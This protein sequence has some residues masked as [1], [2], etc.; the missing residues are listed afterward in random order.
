PN[1]EPERLL[2]DNLPDELYRLHFLVD[3]GSDTIRREEEISKKAGDVVGLI[4]DALL[5]QYKDPSNPESLKSLNELCV[6]IVFLLYAEDADVFTHLQFHDYLARHETRDARRALI[7][8]FRVLDTPPDKRDPYLEAD[9]A[10]FP[11]VNGGLFANENIEIP[12]FTDEILDL[13]LRKGSEDFNWKDISPTIFGAVFESTLNPETRRSGGMHYTSVANIHK[14]ID[15][16]FLDALTRRVDE[17]LSGTS[18]TSATGSG[19][20]QLSQRSQMS[21]SS[22]A[23]LLTLQAE[24]ASLTFLD[25]ACG[26]GNFLTETYIGL[27]RLENRILAALLGGQTMLDLTG[28]MVKVSL[29]QFHGLEINDFAVKVAKTA[30]WIAENQMLRETE[31]IAHR[32]LDFLPLKNYDGIVEGNALRLDWPRAD[33]IIGNPP[34]VG[35]KMM[36][37]EQKED[38]L[39]IFGRKWKNLGNMD[40]VCCWHKKAF[41]LMAANQA[42]RAALVSTNSITQGQA[43]ASLL[44]PLMARGLVIDFAHRTFRWDSESNSKAH[45]HCVIIGFHS[46]G[47]GGPPANGTTRFQR[48]MDAQDAHPTN[49]GEP[50]ATRQLFDG[51]RVSFVP[52]INGYL[53]PAPDVVIDN[54]TRPLC[55]VPAMDF[56]NMPNDGGNLLLTPEEREAVLREEPALSSVIR[57]FI[58]AV[59]FINRKCRYC[60]WLEGTSP[61]FLRA[62][63]ILRARVEAV[64]ELRLASTAAPTREKANIPHLF[65]YISHP[66]TPYLIVPSVSSERR[67]YIPIGFMD[68][69]TIASNLVLIVPKA[70][71][72]HFGVLTSNVHMAWLRAV[73]GRLKSDYR[74]SNKVVYNNFPWP[75]PTEEQESRIGETARGILSAREAHPDCTF[76]DLYDE[77]TMPPDLRRAH[78][79]ND[80]AVMAAYGFSTKMTESECVA[81]LFRRYQALVDAKGKGAK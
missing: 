71:H 32:N 29:S 44:G 18:G 31:A 68:A 25:P 19:A 34:F 17:A 12:Q 37:A 22:R 14:V 36:D 11:Y 57:P 50:P 55:D 33:Y 24:L 67:R 13:V 1:A 23:A 58:G 7:D 20:S 15:P 16:L 47:A 28:D 69:G 73:G 53:L 81:E 61:A 51:E 21:Q 54:R 63:P 52:H 40:Y 10:A 27:R 4:Y 35:G 26:S 3:T 9:L 56:G 48:V 45:V 60:F 75:E 80:R 6:R 49:A 38:M 59:E 8:L 65:F 2:L 78:Q 72:Y 79:E 64:R 62:S 76:A 43:V 42:A 74:Y 39:S 30:L 70:T 5:K 66:D 77:L 41:D 46:G